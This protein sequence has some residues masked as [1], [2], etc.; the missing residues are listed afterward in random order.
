MKKIISL[1]IILG[2]VL[3]FF[4]FKSVYHEEIYIV[5]LGDSLS[6]GY[7]AYDTKGY[8]FNDYL[9]DDYEEKTHIKEYIT[10]FSSPKETSETLLLKLKNNYSIE[11]TDLSITQA[12]SKS[13]ILTIA[14]GM[15]ELNQNNKLNRDEIEEYL[16]N[17]EQILKLVNIYSKKQIYVISLYQTQL[18][19]EVYLD[20]INNRLEKIC[21]EQ[22]IHFLD[23]TEIPIQK[24]FF[25][26]NK[27][28][29]INYKGHKYIKERLLEQM[30]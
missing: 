15:Y 14:L 11:G 1:T 23:M 18:L 10:E 9:R 6:L 22:N 26:N 8:S 24:E 27:S 7:T 4:I 5:T 21:Q 29:L 20:E 25:F 17:M 28:Y 2:T 16:K 3:A 19:N 30:E 12:I 13:T